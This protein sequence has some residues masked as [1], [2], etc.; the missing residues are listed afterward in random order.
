MAALALDEDKGNYNFYEIFD[1]ETGKPEGGNQ[2]GRAVWHSR[3]HQTWSATGYMTMVC[4]GICGLRPNPDGIEIRPYLPRGIN[5]LSI[6]GLKIREDDTRH[7]LAGTRLPNRR[8]PGRRPEIRESFHRGGRDRTA[9]HRDPVGSASIPVIAPT[10][11]ASA[12]KAV[13]RILPH[14]FFFPEGKERSYGRSILKY[15][16]AFPFPV[17]ITCSCRHVLRRSFAPGFRNHRVRR[18]RN[19]ALLCDNYIR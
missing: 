16:A 7:R 10:L 18:V 13:R 12:R 19:C 8:F 5:R 4:Q 17:R 15:P 1:P 11:H 9:T 6:K 3:R 2:A 14:R